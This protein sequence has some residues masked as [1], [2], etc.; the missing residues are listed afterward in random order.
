MPGEGDDFTQSFLFYRPRW[1]PRVEVGA[2]WIWKD[3][4][5]R[6]IGNVDLIKES[7]TM[8]YLRVGVAYQD[9]FSDKVAAFGAGGPSFGLQHTGHDVN[10]YFGLY[11][12]PFSV[13][14]WGNDHRKLGVAVSVV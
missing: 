4:I 8:P 1:H 11:F 13:S 7:Q 2:A 6:L 12:A 10:I 9:T 14:V 3:S 5:V